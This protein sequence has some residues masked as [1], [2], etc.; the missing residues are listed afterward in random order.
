MP[1][2][3]T[4]TVLLDDGETLLDGC[5]RVDPVQVVETDAVGAKST[6]ALL[7]LSLKDLRAT[8][9]GAA[10]APLGC[11]NATVRNGSKRRTDRGLAFSAGY[12]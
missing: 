2:L 1:D 4:V 8:A 10:E 7:D 9:T 6:K 12:V 3:A 5:L 11:Y